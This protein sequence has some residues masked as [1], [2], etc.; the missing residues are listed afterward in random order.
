M[1]GF[2]NLEGVVL[3]HPSRVRALAICCFS[4]GNTIPSGVIILKLI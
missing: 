3:F 2:H 1:T 4:R